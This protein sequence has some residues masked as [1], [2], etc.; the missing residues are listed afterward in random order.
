MLRRE[1]R[2]FLFGLLQLEAIHFIFNNPGQ[3]QGTRDQAFPGA[4]F[5]LWLWQFLKASLWR[6]DQVRRGQL[7]L[8]ML[9]EVPSFEAAIITCAA[10]RYPA[11]TTDRKQ[12]GR[13]NSLAVTSSMS[14]A[15]GDRQNKSGCTLQCWNGSAHQFWGAPCVPEG[16][17]QRMTS[18]CRFPRY[19]YT[20]DEESMRQKAIHG[21]LVKRQLATL[22]FPQPSLL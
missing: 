14:E 22:R 8:R 16:Q 7:C 15:A 5:S 17:T 10:L 19:K 3:R 13:T 18:S 4:R 20:E 1:N 12:S 2:V 6:G 9:V 11:L 21:K